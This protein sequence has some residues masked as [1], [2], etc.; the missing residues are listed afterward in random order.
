MAQGAGRIRASF[1]PSG[2]ALSSPDPAL[3]TLLL[4]FAEGELAWPQGG[5]AFLRAREGFALRQQISLGASALDELLCEQ[6]FK[7]DAD[8][9]LR[10]GLDAVE[11]I[12]EARRFALVLV[13]PPRSREEMRGLFARALALC[14]PG[15]R[16]L[17]CMGNDEGAKSGEK[18]LQQ[19][20]GLGGKLTKNHCR[21]F[22]TPPLAGAHDAA[23]HAQWLQLD[24]PRVLANAQA[25]GGAFVSRPG[26]FAWDRV[27]AASQL[28]AENLPHD[29]RGDGADLGGGWGFLATRVLARN[30]EVRE[31]HLFEAEARA[32]ECARQNLAAQAGKARLHW[33][34]VMPGLPRQF[35]F[36]VM[37]PPFHAMRKNE[38]VDI[39]RRF[40]E[41]AAEALHPGGSLW[42]VANRHLPYEQVLGEKFASVRVVAGHDGF[43]VIHAIKSTGSAA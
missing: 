17:A 39:G 38:R 26:I 42:L 41:V 23:L 18:D 19:L 32:L 8:A 29:L 7:P 14:A 12:D 3:E 2:V 33:H 37:N 25:V 20:A 9:L 36:V 16:V 13:L 43:K 11:R 1:L 24:A 4:P 35:D 34:D 21:V 27:D 15:G 22:W 31:L 10:G 40:I 5:V 6:S 28:L 30:P